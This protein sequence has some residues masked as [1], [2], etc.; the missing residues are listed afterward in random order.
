VS[1]QPFDLIRGT[2]DLD[3]Q[4]AL[5]AGSLKVLEQRPSGT[6][7]RALLRRQR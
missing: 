7:H 3:L 4:A 6:Y 2:S 1:I 5:I